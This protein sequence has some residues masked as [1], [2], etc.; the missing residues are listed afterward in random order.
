MSNNKSLLNELGTKPTIAYWSAFGGVEIKGI[1]YG[2]EDYVLCISGAWCSQPSAH[3]LK[4]Q[5]Y[6]DRQF[7]ML[8]GNRLYLD[9][10]IR[11]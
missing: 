7:V 9:E 6:N 4:I 1:E 10:A 11:S 3:K 5:V 8:N 2:I